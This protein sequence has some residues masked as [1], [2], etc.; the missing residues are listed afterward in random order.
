MYKM[1]TNEY[2]D[3]NQGRQEETHHSTPQLSVLIPRPDSNGMEN[4][5][6]RNGSN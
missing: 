4:M 3:H 2:T 1:K 5:C 6:Q